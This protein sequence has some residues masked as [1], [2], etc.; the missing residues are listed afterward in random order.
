MNQEAVRRMIRTISDLADLF[1]RP[2]LLP[3]VTVAE[4]SAGRILRSIAVELAT[5][6]DEDKK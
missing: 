4:L 5:K 3:A 6:I 2:N 1:D